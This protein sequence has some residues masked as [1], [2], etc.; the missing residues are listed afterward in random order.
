MRR[1]PPLLRRAWYSLNQA[2]RQRIAP[3]GITPDQYSILRWLNE[4]PPEGLT[5]TEITERMT[6]DPATITSTLRRMEIS[7]MLSRTR[8]ES[9]GRAKRVRLLP[10]GNSLFNQAQS[11]AQSL[12]DKVLGGLA[13]EEGRHFLELL[14]KIASAC[15]AQIHSP[16]PVSAARKLRRKQNQSLS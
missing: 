1:F 14:E 12:Q 16:T 10:K 2:F 6:S 8:H 13:P 4:S 9:D 7:G 5:Q 3:L 15:A 11:I